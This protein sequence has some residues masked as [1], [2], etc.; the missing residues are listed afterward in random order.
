MPRTKLTQIVLYF[1][2]RTQEGSQK[3]YKD[4][5]ECSTKKEKEKV[6]KKKGLRFVEV[7]PLVEVN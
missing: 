7:S 5:L 2:P 1:K 3:T 6:M 4:A